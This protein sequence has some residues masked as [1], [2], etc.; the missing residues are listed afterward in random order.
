MAS[1]EMFSR[2]AF[3]RTDV[4]AQLSASIIRVTRISDLGTFAVSSNRR[5]LRVRR[6]LLTANVPRSLVL[7]TLMMEALSSSET[8][9][10][11]RIIRRNITEDAILHSH[12]R[13]NLKYYTLKPNLFIV[14]KSQKVRDTVLFQVFSPPCSL[15]QLPSKF[16]RG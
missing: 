9:G 8:S 3:V 14:E 16:R 6:L 10:L 15:C 13:G 7:V 4:S 11:T 12:R 1:S 5:T 2:V